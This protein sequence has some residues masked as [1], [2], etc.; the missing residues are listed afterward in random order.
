MIRLDRVT[1]Q[2]D[3]LKVVDSVSFE[4]SEG[5]LLVLLGGSG[6]GKTTTM[7]MINRLVEPT[8]GTIEVDGKDNRSMEPHLLRREIGYVFQAIG[9]FP[10][11]TVAENIGITL[12][13]LGWGAEKIQ[14]RATDLLDAMALDEELRERYPHQLSGGQKQRVGVARALAARPKVVLFDEPFGALDPATRDQLQELV[15]RIKEKQGLTAI[16]VTHD[17]PEALRV[18]DRIAVMH[19]GVLQQ[20]GTTHE[21]V[22]EPAT[23]HVAALFEAPRQHLRELSEL[24]RG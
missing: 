3:D 11:L 16:F 23:E 20:I 6:S 15:V 5:E 22:N 10:H 14:A 7:K 21:V 8:S 1:K 13:L 4:V 9:L 17:V 12:S 19:E 24:M 2:Y 18:A